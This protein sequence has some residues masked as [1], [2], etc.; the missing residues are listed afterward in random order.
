MIVDQL[1]RETTILKYFNDYCILLDMYSKVR[2]DPENIDVRKMI[3]QELLT[4]RR[5]ARKGIKE[6]R[7]V[8][9]KDKIQLFVST[10]SIEGYFI[11]LKVAKKF[12]F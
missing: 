4:I 12:K 6:K 5:M 7:G 11:V 3:K 10:Y 9:I 1:G 2:K 8:R